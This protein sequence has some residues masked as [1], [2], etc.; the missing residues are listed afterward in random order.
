MKLTI[1]EVS[2]EQFNEILTEG[3]PPTTDAAPSS[4]EAI[5]ECGHAENTHDPCCVSACGCDGFEPRKPS[6]EQ[7]FKFVMREIKEVAQDALGYE[8]ICDPVQAV[9]RLAQEF[10]AIKAQSAKESKQIE[11]LFTEGVNR[12][13]RENSDESP[14]PEGS[15]A[16]HWETRGYAYQA[17]A[18]RAVELEAR[19][20]VL[21]AQLL[22][23]SALLG[24]PIGHGVG[25]L[26]VAEAVRVAK[27]LWEVADQDRVA[28]RN[29]AKL[30][31]LNLSVSEERQADLAQAL[32]TICD[33][34]FDIRGDCVADARK[35]AQAALNPDTREE[36]VTE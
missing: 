16:R 6:I 10:E 36:G 19:I 17:R 21:E 29:I 26:C 31:R 27:R 11:S 33:W 25:L 7:V 22:E 3:A 32:Q 15:P 12:C 30:L 35:L 13:M 4:A 23:A 34:P 5:C 28:S 18:F 14:Y 8:Q 9:R 24:E 1:T 2:H 20:R